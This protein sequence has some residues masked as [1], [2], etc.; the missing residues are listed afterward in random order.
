M[1]AIQ[2]AQKSGFSRLLFDYSFLSFCILFFIFQ[3]KLSKTQ[4]PNIIMAPTP[5]PQQLPQ[6]DLASF[7]KLIKYF[8]SKQYNPALQEAKNLLR[9]H[10]NHGETISMKA[11]IMNALGKKDEAEVLAKEGLKN[12]FKSATCW[13]VIGLLESKKKNYAKAINAY[14]SALKNE[15]TNYIVQRDLAGVQHV[16]RMF[17]NFRSTRSDM[18]PAKSQQHMAWIGFSIANYH[19]GVENIE[20]NNMDEANL[21]LNA[22]I[23]TLKTMSETREKMKEKNKFTD[24]DKYEMSELNLFIAH[25]YIL[26]KN[27]KEL[28]AFF[29]FCEGNSVVDMVAL[30]E[31]KGRYYLSRAEGSLEKDEKD[32]NNNDQLT[33]EIKNSYFKQAEKEFTWLIYRNPENPYYYSALE[34]IVR[35]KDVENKIKFLDVI[36]QKF[37]R[38][39]APKRLVLDFLQVDHPEFES[40]LKEYLLTGIEKGRPALFQDVKNLYNWFR[41]LFY[42][43][44][45]CICFIFQPLN[46]ITISVPELNSF[47]KSPQNFLIILF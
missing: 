6:K 33:P 34:K 23:A 41:M 31:M 26:Q 22:A 30:R 24:S 5:D 38:A 21:D 3:N 29:E 16:L 39:L 18:V 40:K 32:E 11:L 12:N 8:D 47:K 45:C 37:P 7:Q 4:N 20:K 28:E 19:C 13:H 10:P 42:L 44:L 17:Q 15:P 35:P 9:K 25:L 14:T 36:G 43:Y 27:Y 46:F 2:Y 1:H